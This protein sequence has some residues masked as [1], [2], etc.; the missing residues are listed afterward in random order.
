ME[1]LNPNEADLTAIESLRRELCGIGRRLFARRLVSGTS[2]NISVRVPEYADREGSTSVRGDSVSDTSLSGRFLIT[3]SGKSFED[4]S[5]EEFLLVNSCGEV[6]LGRGKPS[7]EW[8]FHRG[9]YSV[10]PDVQAVVHGHSAYATAYVMAAGQLPVVTV[11][12]RLGL[13]S[14]GIVDYAPPGS[15]ELA[16]KVTEVFREE[17]MRAAILCDHGF[18]TVG[19]SLKPAYYL[20]D[21]LEENAKVACLR[22]S[23]NRISFN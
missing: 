9:I 5:E 17:E 14:I 11:E 18:I 19:D 2:G 21:I 12:A 23:L 20:A 8:A 3:A 16:A 6:L 1:K 4:V 15:E 10:R 13:G 7:M 22:Q